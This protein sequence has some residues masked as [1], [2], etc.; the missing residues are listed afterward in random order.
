MFS[1]VIWRVLLLSVALFLLASCSRGGAPESSTKSAVTA[2]RSVSAAAPKAA[3][4]SNAASSMR[5]GT[6]DY[7]GITQFGDR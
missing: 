4:T 2:T 3:K 1:S 5:K 7:N 6:S